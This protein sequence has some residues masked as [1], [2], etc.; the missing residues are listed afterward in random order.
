MM[1]RKSVGEGS[2]AREESPFR[3]SM[4][5]HEWRGGPLNAL[6]SN[7]EE[8]RTVAPAK[9]SEPPFLAGAR[10]RMHICSNPGV[11]CIYA[12]IHVGRT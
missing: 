9:K 1:D 3:D 8:S 5:F 11:A 6:E 10:S 12:Y 7:G 2:C 4:E